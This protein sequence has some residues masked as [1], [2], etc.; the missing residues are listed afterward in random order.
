MCLRN[1]LYPHTVCI[2]LELHIHLIYFCLLYC[3][4]D[5]RHYTCIIPS[6]HI[7]RIEQDY[8]SSY[9]SA[10]LCEHIWRTEPCSYRRNTWIH[11]FVNIH[12]WNLI[13]TPNGEAIYKSF[14]KSEHITIK[15]LLWI[16]FLVNHKNKTLIR[17]R[18]SAYVYVKCKNVFEKLLVLLKHAC[19]SIV[20]SWQPP[21]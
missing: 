18:K 13:I 19:L 10:L 1:I 12:I 2:N 3:F 20:L 16:F 9:W 6:D 8:R 11:R 21:E 14:V 5:Q 15:V 4:T 17:F 7:E